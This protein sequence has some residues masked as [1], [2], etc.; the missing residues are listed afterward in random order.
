MAT[1]D[2]Q[3]GVALQEERQLCEHYRNRNLIL[4]QA[5]HDL[6][7]DVARLEALV[8]AKTEGDDS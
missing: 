3:T 7:Q 5:V 4:A 8:A 1:V 2:I 6:R